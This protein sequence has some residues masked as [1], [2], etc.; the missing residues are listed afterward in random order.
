MHF[1][2]SKL[3]DLAGHDTRLC[4]SIHYGMKPKTHADC[5]KLPQISEDP[6]RRSSPPSPS[7]LSHPY[8]QKAISLE[9]PA[10]SPVTDGI[11]HFVRKS[12]RNAKKEVYWLFV[13]KPDI[14]YAD[15]ELLC[16]HYWTLRSWNLLPQS[17]QSGP[18][19][20]RWWNLLP[21]DGRPGWSDRVWRRC[22]QNCRLNDGTSN[23]GPHRCTLGPSLPIS[24]QK[25]MMQR[26]FDQN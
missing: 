21:S 4:I 24:A 18:H 15:G 8:Y 19:R 3:G 2:A 23:F 9:Y 17:S 13:W 16:S 25:Q 20:I 22:S 12:M 26:F 7:P 10:T 6:V 11:H 1:W 14:G 5:M